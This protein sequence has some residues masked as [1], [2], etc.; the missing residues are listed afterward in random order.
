MRAAIDFA[1]VSIVYD[2]IT[3]VP[4]ILFF[5]IE[6]HRAE[7]AY[8]VVAPNMTSYSDDCERV[9]HTY[10]RYSIKSP[11]TCNQLVFK[12]YTLSIG[13]CL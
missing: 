7:Y 5:F 9:S 13:C 2:R 6:H 4:S 11:I 12:S 8:D 10:L 3:H 1:L